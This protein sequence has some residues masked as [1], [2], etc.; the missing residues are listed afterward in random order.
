MLRAVWNS[1]SSS[2]RGYAARQLARDAV[3]LA[4]EKHVDQHE[5]DLRV[6][7]V[8]P[9]AN[10]VSSRSGGIWSGRTTSIT[11]N[12]GFFAPASYR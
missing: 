2:Q 11:E 4:Q 3:V 6:G 7:R 10:S 1:R 8:A 5:P 9:A 12:S